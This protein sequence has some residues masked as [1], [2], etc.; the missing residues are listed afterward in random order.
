MRSQLMAI[1]RHHGSL[2]HPLSFGWFAARWVFFADSVVIYI[3]DLLTR[4]QSRLVTRLLCL[5]STAK[6]GSLSSVFFAVYRLIYFYVTTDR[7]IPHM[8]AGVEDTY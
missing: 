6:K 4:A 3:I 1:K 5:R 7:S 2:L 8:T